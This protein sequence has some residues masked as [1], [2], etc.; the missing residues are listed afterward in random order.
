MN[1]GGVVVVTDSLAVVFVNEDV[2]VVFMNY[3][4]A[5]VEL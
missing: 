1:D 2:V 4:Y 5:E 3:G